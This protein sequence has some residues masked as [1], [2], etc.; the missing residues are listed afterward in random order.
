MKNENTYKLNLILSM[1]IFGTIG[2]VVRNIPLPSSFIA[3]ARGA[4][5]SVVLVLFFVIRRRKLSLSAIRQNIAPLLISGVVLG[6]NWI[7]LFEAYRY[8]TV[9][10]ATLCYYMAPVFVMIVSPL[11][12]HEKPESHRVI[13]V[14]VSLV[15]MVLVSGITDFRNF[16][17]SEL[18]GVLLGLLAAS[19]YCCIVICNKKLTNI[20]S[21]DTTV[22]QLAVSAVTM[23][24]YVLITEDVTAFVFTK[25]SVLWLLTAGIVHTGVAYLLYFAS[26]NKLKAQ[27]TA[28]YS[29]I[30]PLVAVAVSVLILKEGMTLLSVVGAL[31]ILGSTLFSELFSAKK[32]RT[33]DINKD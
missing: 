21:E 13:C 9:A 4:I 10:T 20:G 19:L 24:I 18:R 2:L 3:F 31:L 1:L 7:S 11:F 28:V 16:D 22:I 29:Y 33:V 15:G 6:L 23:L 26:V 27:T 14:L 30:D 25:S 12:L 5:G 8:T 17:I 32:K